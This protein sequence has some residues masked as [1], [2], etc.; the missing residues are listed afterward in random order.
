MDA[1]RSREALGVVAGVFEGLPGALQ[2]EPELRIHHLG[3][4]RRVVEEA[5]VEEIGLGEHATRL[6]VARIA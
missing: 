1:D 4:Q 5:G 3:L 6:D 2:E